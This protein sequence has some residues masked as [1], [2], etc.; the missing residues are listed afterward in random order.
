VVESSPVPHRLIGAVD[1]P[2]LDL[3]WS[4]AFDAIADT[5]TYLVATVRPDGAPHVVPVLGV[6]VGQVLYF[7]SGS[8]AQKARNLHQNPQISV[9]APGTSYDFVIDGSA[10]PVTEPEVLERV[11]AAFPRKYP[12]WHP[13]VR[14]G[15]FVAAE[16]D[17]TPRI[18]FAV[19][20]RSVFGFGKAH[21]FSATRWSFD[22][23]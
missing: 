10:T 12:W 11:A 5:E 1:V 22:A 2:A 18:V 19:A 20:P 3:A 17:D 21:G 15:A 8:A 9:T 23:N 6:W 4:E 14:D 16:E 13:Q 7:N